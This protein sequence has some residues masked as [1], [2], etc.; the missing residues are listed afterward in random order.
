MFDI[1]VYLYETYYR[2][3]TCPD[4]IVL[5][6]KLSA[7]GF[8][9]EE[10]VEAL[11][12]LS[13]LDDTNK[14]LDFVVKRDHPTV[15]LPE[16]VGFRIY[17]EQESSCLGS[18]G[19]GFV[20]Y[21]EYTKLLNWQQREVVIERVLALDE[22]PIALEKLKLVVLMIFWSQGQAPNRLMFDDLLLTDVD[23]STQGIFH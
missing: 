9:E 10:I 14:H 13:A 12:W 18:R 11:D 4:S 17:T 8:E 5:A 22:F 19:I 21:L 3:D 6:K 20:Q 2:P 15:E 1:F 23:P 16:K 7:I